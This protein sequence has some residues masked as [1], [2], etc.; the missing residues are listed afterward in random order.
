MDRIDQET[1]PTQPTTDRERLQRRGHS[2]I[3][4]LLDVRDR[5]EQWQ[6]PVAIVQFRDGD[7]ETV[8]VP[9]AHLTDASWEGRGRE[10]V[11]VRRM[12]R[13]EVAELL[14]LADDLAQDVTP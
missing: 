10:R 7:C 4:A 2:G 8:A 14:E 12:D 5:L 6:F 13:D 11:V 3:A 9:D 1:A